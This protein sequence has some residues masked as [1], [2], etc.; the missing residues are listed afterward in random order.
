[1]P[2]IH[3]IH[4]NDEWTAPLRVELDALGLPYRD[5]FLDTGVVDLKS[6]PPE[7]VFYNRMSA[8]SHTRAHRFAPELAGAV[9][10]WLEGHGRCVLNPVRALQ[11]EI[12]KVAQYA[13][14][15]AAGVRTPRTVAAV[16]KREILNAARRFEGPFITKHNRGGKGLGVE[17]FHHHTELEAYVYGP[18]FQTP[19]D[20]V[21]LVQE[22]IHAP[23]PFITRLEFIGGNFL[24]ALR[25]DTSNGFELCPADACETIAQTPKFTIDPNFEHPLVA[26]Y[27]RFL[28]TQS[29]HVAGVEFIV[30]AAGQDYTYDINTNTNYNAAAETLA[31][32]NGMRALARYLGAEL[33]RLTIATENREHA[34]A[35]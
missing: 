12:S 7:G 15:E 16:G 1:M 26:K 33:T 20:G 34:L 19:V 29:I 4:E 9:L 8:S 2:E 32:V 3:I 28:K 14:L 13:A 21:T 24:Y 5:W 18:R 25:A 27:Q 22:Y 11:L 10:S 30:D 17:L 35:S 6:A 31:G 23:E